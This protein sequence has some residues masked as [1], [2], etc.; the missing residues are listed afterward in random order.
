MQPSFL[1]IFIRSEVIS[2]CSS[3]EINIHIL[4]IEFD[5][6]TAGGSHSDESPDREADEQLSRVI[7]YEDVN[8]Y[9]FSLSSG[10]ARLS[11]VSHFIDFFGGKISQW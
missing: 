9:L 1:K 8:E 6:E 3:S 5:H 2:I 7:L 11:L 4:Q 10:E